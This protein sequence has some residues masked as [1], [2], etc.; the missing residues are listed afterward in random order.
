MKEYDVLIVGGGPAGA[1]CARRLVQSGVRCLVLDRCTFPRNKPCAGWITPDVWLELDAAPAEYPHPL[2]TFRALNISIHGIPLLR[3]GRQYAI[4]RTEFDAW[5]LQRSKAPNVQHHVQDIQILDSGFLIDGKWSGRHLVGAGGTYCPVCQKLFKPDHPRDPAGRIVAM[6]EEFRYPWRDGKC[7]LWF[8]ENGLPGY[9][10]YVPKAG[11]W[12][13]VGVGGMLERMKERGTTITFHWEKF[14][15]KLERSGLVRGRRFQPVSHVYYRNARISEIQRGH[16]YLVGDAAGLATLDMGEGIGPAVR[17][18]ILAA[19]A[20][21]RGDR[22][23][24]S[25]I[26][27]YSLL[28]RLLQKRIPH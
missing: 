3:P 16:A 9:A 23:S 24:V 22:Y 7:R 17:S 2:T 8:T 6:E 26:P 12:V 4:R 27:R 20:I 15:E 19:E 21:I 13:N 14:I 18:G 11:G 28:P 1:A 5:M 25:S 10:W